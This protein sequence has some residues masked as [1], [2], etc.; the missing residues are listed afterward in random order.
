M[1]SIE[2]SE[3]SFSPFFL[4][5][6]VWLENGDSNGSQQSDGVH[7]SELLLAAGTKIEPFSLYLK[8]KTEKKNLPIEANGVLPQ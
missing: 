5:Q 2:E 1:F 4:Q 7:C 8:E 3:V 6:A